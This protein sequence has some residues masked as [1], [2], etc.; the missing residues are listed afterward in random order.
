[1]E[2]RI[3]F[4]RRHDWRAF[5]M[6]QQTAVE[7][8]L[9]LP[10]SPEQLWADLTD[11]EEVGRWF[12]ATVEWDLVP[13]GLIHVSEDDGTER[14]GVIE[15]VEPGH[16]LRFRWWTPGERP[17]EV[18]YRLEE[19]DGGTRL[20][21]VEQEL[22][23]GGGEA[24]GPPGPHEAGQERHDEPQPAPPQASAATGS[25]ASMAAWGTRMAGLWLC[26]RLPAAA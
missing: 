8:D 14:D 23:P 22:P 13:G 5:E 11:P 4:G 15:A 20:T 17:S 3:R 16:Q 26:C 6:D 9:V 12:G 7:Q 2:L 1:M 25:V 21:V 19:V 10:V 24:D 18:H